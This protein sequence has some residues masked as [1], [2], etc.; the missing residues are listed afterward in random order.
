MHPILILARWPALP[1]TAAVDPYGGQYTILPYPQEHSDVLLAFAHIPSSP[2]DMSY[3]P[4]FVPL[5]T[6][7]VVLVSTSESVPNSSE[8]QNHQYVVP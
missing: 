4:P 6:R 8:T 3:A 2:I 7:L 5:A 1:S